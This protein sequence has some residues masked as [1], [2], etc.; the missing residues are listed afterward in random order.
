[1]LKRIIL[2]IHFSSL[3]ICLGVI[4]LMIPLYLMVSVKPSFLWFVSLPS[5]VWM[6]YFLD[7]YLDIK[8]SSVALSKRH[9]FLQK[10]QKIFVFLFWSFFIFNSAFFFTHFSQAQLVKALSLVVTC[11]FYFLCNYF[12]TNWFL[13]EIL[14]AIIY[15]F[16][17]CIYPYL[18]NENQINSQLII[19]YYGQLIFFLAII[20]LF[21][22]SIRETKIDTA[23]NVHNITRLVGIKLSKLML[24]VFYG[25]SIYFLIITLV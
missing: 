12:L 22:I 21:Q 10:K 4:S 17:I 24:V 2:F 13:K 19:L 7:H 6:I 23:F 8:K 25:L 11:V 9:L 18:I 3:D 1:M 20:N 16:G 15:A 14:A 5:T